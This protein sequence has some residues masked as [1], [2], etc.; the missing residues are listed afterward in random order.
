MT[1]G[2]DPKGSKVFLDYYGFFCTFDIVSILMVSIGIDGLV[3]LL[4]CW[5]GVAPKK[6][7]QSS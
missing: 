5:E 2:N 7:A 3:A 6:M 4:G 1:A